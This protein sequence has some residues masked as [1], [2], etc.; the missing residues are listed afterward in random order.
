MRGMPRGIVSR[1]GPILFPSTASPILREFGSEQ[2]IV[3]AL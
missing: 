2:E 3:T 1:K